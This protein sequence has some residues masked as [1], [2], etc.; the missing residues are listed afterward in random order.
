L[1]HRQGSLFHISDDADDGIPWP[2]G[3]TNVKTLAERA[4]TR[5]LALR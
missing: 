4:L 5:K 3:G 1:V 2:G